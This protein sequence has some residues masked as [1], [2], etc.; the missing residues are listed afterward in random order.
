M[1]DELAIAL[2]EELKKTNEHLEGIKSELSKTREELSEGID[3]FNANSEK[4]FFI[5][6]GAIPADEDVVEAAAKYT[7][8]EAQQ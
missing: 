6:H 1:Q 2:I 3:V 7:E 8:Q 5:I 4:L